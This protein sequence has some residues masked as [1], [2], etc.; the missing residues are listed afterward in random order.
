M[1]CLGSES[2]DIGILG[3][4]LGELAKDFDGPVEKVAIVAGELCKTKQCQLTTL[5]TIPEA[6]TLGALRMG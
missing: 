4:G 5:C 2:G 6:G 3:E 1:V